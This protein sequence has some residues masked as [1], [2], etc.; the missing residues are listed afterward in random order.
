MPTQEEVIHQVTT[1]VHRISRDAKSLHDATEQSVQDMRKSAHDMHSRMDQIEMAVKRGGGMIGASAETAE[2]KAYKTAFDGFVRHGE[3]AGLKAMQHKALSVGSDVEGGY[4]VPT[5]LA[6]RIVKKV[7]EVSPL[8]QLASVTT[9]SG[10]DVELLVDADEA[11]AVWSDE[12]SPRGTTKTPQ[13]G[14][15]RI[16]AHELTANPLATQKL[17]EDA[18]INVDDWLTTKIS[19]RFARTEG[20]T[21]VTGTGSGQPFGFL[22]SKSVVRLPS[23]SLG[24]LTPDAILAM[25]YSLKAA[26]RAQAAWLMPRSVQLKVR[27]LK[28]SMGQYLWRPGLIAGQPDT[29]VGYPVYDCEDM[30]DMAPG[31]LSVAFGAWKEAYQIVD[32]LGIAIQRDPFTRKP[33]VEFSARKRVGGDVVNPEAIA[34]METATS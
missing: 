7:F 1:E 30:P 15:L 4:Y 19:Q 16:V 10:T 33:W 34:F 22:R 17:L 3:D 20:A 29:L 31:S 5:Q 8:R 28:D 12:T 21:F 18:A 25:V 26:Y 6:D 23:G 14:K 13:L 24:G 27:L 9:I 11:E 32:R 2:Q